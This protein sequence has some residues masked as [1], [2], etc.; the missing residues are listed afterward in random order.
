MAKITLARIVE[1]RQALTNPSLTYSADEWRELLALAEAF[2]RI[3]YLNRTE[4]CSMDFSD[5]VDAV[6]ME[7]R[8]RIAADARKATGNG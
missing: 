6:I 5:A 4:N 8:E 7:T 2:L 1:L 3:E